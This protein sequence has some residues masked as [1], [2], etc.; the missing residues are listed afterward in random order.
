MRRPFVL[1]L[2]TI[3]VLLLGYVLEN[4]FVVSGSA[5]FDQQAADPTKTSFDTSPALTTPI[6]AWF[7]M[8]ASIAGLAW[9][10]RQWA[11]ADR[12]SAVV[13]GLIGAVAW[14]LPWLY[15]EPPVGDLL[16][17]WVNHLVGR[18][19]FIPIAG[20]F[21]VVLA[22][23]TLVRRRPPVAGRPSPTDE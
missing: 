15:Y 19:E 10:L 3:G 18:L 17:N 6:I 2:A 23:A 22:L 13:V 16:P 1:G 5:L 12:A 9:L 8:A 21:V 7:L 11:D 14:L 20:A 4:H